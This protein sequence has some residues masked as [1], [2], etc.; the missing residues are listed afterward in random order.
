MYWGRRRL[1]E[2]CYFTMKKHMKHLNL[3]SMF[4]LAVITI[5]FGIF[6]YWL[7]GPVDIIDIK[8]SDA[9]QVDQISYYP[10]ERISYTL[11]YCKFEKKVATVYRSLVD[12]Y[13]IT[14]AVVEADLPVGCH[15]V[16]RND[17]V[18]PSFIVGD[19][20][21]YHLEATTEYKINPIKT[22]TYYWRTVDFLIK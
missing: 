20:H 2:T 19:G 5:G 18:I 3:L 6:G 10:G 9:V 8:N 16:V 4:G 1:V 11:D 21:R 13:R 17:L 12:T 14:Y 22:I 15:T 7:F